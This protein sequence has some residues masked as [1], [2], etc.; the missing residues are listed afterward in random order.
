MAKQI[1]YLHQTDAWCCVTASLSHC[2]RHP[3]SVRFLCVCVS[4]FFPSLMHLKLCKRQWDVRLDVYAYLML[5]MLPLLMRSVLC[6]NA[7]WALR[8]SSRGLSSRATAGDSIAFW[9]GKR[10]VNPTHSC[11]EKLSICGF[12][13][14]AIKPFHSLFSCN[15][16]HSRVFSVFLVIY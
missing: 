5:Q 13:A 10:W 3:A 7:G 12:T 16:L 8:S 1:C 9:N 6:L 11:C 14:P 2:G 15:N 4:A